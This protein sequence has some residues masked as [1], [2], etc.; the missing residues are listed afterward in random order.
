MEG[1]V[2]ALQALVQQLLDHGDEEAGAGSGAAGVARAA[3]ITLLTLRE[4]HKQR[5]L[6]TE[7]LKEQTNISKTQLDQSSMQL[8]NLLY[9][10]QHY[11]K[12]IQACR[13]FASE[14]TDAQVDLAPVGELEASASEPIKAT[15]D[16]SEHRLMLARLQFE[17]A[18]RQQLAADLEALQQEKQQ[19]LQ[20]L[21]QRKGRLDDLK[22]Q[23][24]AIGEQG[25]QLEPFLAPLVGLKTLPSAAASLP[26]PLY[27]LFSQLAAAQEALQLPVAVAVSEIVGDR[28]QL[29][30]V[31]DRS[32][33][34]AADAEQGSK[35]R[36]SASASGA[37][38][39]VLKVRRLLEQG[40]AC[41]GWTG[42]AGPGS[43]AARAVAL[44]PS[45]LVSRPCAAV[46]QHQRASIAPP[47]CL[48]QPPSPSPCRAA[49]AQ[50]G[51]AAHARARPAAAL[52]QQ[53]AQLRLLHRRQAGGRVQREQGGAAAGGQGGP[54]RLRRRAAGPGRAVCPGGPL[55]AGL[56]FARHQQA[57]SWATALT[58]SAGG[59]R[60][61]CWGAGR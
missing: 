19:A 31:V 20:K 55:E 9:E 29:G 57:G 30:L 32:E 7:A 36:R 28:A 54:L 13:S 23:L 27:V 25:K 34:A 53:H 42:Q 12:E 3:F 60:G 39:D 11:E 15:L 49:G 35:R 5:C 37:Q 33:A 52:Q 44:P 26:T 51:G 4:Q 10:K 46:H 45:R 1:G 56:P 2:A 38:Q 47:P 48:A 41:R 21:Q 61:S 40:R 6:D 18:Q 59:C 14:V 22:T 58:G 17:K 50:G 43:S 24:A 8:Q 16:G